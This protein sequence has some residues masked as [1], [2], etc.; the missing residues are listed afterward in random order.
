VEFSNQPPQDTSGGKGKS[1]RGNEKG[2][3]KGAGR[4]ENDKS[5]NSFGFFDP[6]PAS[7]NTLNTP[8][9]HPYHTAGASDNSGFDHVGE[10]K[11][12]RESMLQELHSGGHI[13]ERN[14]KLQLEPHP[15]SDQEVMPYLTYCIYD[16]RSLWSKDEKAQAEFLKAKEEKEKVLLKKQQEQEENGDQAAPDV[17]ENAGNEFAFPVS[18]GLLDKADLAADPIQDVG[19]ITSKYL[20]P[21]AKFQSKH[22]N[23]LIRVDLRQTPAEMMGIP[24]QNYFYMCS[25]I[26]TPCTVS[27]TR[28]LRLLHAFHN[29]HTSLPSDGD[30]PP[31]NDDQEYVRPEVITRLLELCDCFDVILEGKDGRLFLLDS[32]DMLEDVCMFAFLKLAWPKLQFIQGRHEKHELY[33]RMLSENDKSFLSDWSLVLRRIMPV[34]LRILENVHA[35]DGLTLASA[36]F[37][38]ARLLMQENDSRRASVELGMA[39]VRLDNELVRSSCLGPQPQLDRPS[40]S[41]VSF[42]PPSVRPPHFALYEDDAKDDSAND[43]DKVLLLGR[44]SRLEQERICLL[45]QLYELWIDCSLKVHFKNV[46]STVKRVRKPG[47]AVEDELS[48]VVESNSTKLS[49]SNQEANQLQ[50]P[51]Q[52]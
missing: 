12:L 13:Y 48:V 41:A 1:K 52:I 33:E 29:L 36:A 26:D 5:A 19:I 31:V 24:L 2:R 43:A 9:M 49:L 7:S 21:E 45:T 42:D 37:G 22:F 20:H 3:G 16:E 39:I 32:A 46:S 50:T 47:E 11:H 10:S 14:L 28:Q 38:L 35:V 30:E 44:Q 40:A 8:W 25:S 27:V 18:C 23:A 34:L 4:V 17:N 51:W 6:A 15:G